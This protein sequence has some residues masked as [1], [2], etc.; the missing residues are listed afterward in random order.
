M[1]YHLLFLQKPLLLG[2]LLWL[3]DPQ[4]FD[5]IAAEDVNILESTKMGIFVELEA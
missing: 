3:S 2:C 5:N 1:S 4:S